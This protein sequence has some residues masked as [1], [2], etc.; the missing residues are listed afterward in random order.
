MAGVG[1]LSSGLGGGH[2][3]QPRKTNHPLSSQSGAGKREQPRDAHDEYEPA[4][5]EVTK[6]L[7]AHSIGVWTHGNFVARRKRSGCFSFLPAPRTLFFFELNRTSDFYGVVTCTPLDEPVTEGYSVL[8]FPI[9]WGSRRDGRSDCICKTC[10]RRFDSEHETPAC[11][12]GKA[13]RIC[14]MCYHSSAVLHPFPGE[15]AYGY[16]EYLYRCYY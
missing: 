3:P 16:R 5:G 6:H 2:Q 14:E 12:H 7:R 15:F 4:P 1:A 9:W 10:Y 8:G 11:G 13:E